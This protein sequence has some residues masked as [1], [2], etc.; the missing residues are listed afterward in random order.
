MFYLLQLKKNRQLT[1]QIGNRMFFHAAE[2]EESEGHRAD[3]RR[4]PHTSCQQLLPI[5]DFD[6]P[7][8]VRENTNFEMS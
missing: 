2:P 3:N 5:P 7:L 4:A 1:T 6:T 8:K